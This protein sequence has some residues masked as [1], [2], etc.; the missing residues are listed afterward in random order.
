[1]KLLIITAINAFQKDVKNI[2]KNAGIQTYSFKEVTGYKDISDQS[3]GS[4]WFA[5]ELNETESVLFFAFTENEVVNQVFDLINEFNQQQEAL[6]QIHI[7]VV[8]IA[9]SNQS[10]LK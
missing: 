10:T 2:L 8:E 5:S 7:A 3:I 4:N 9:Q 6:S 1:M